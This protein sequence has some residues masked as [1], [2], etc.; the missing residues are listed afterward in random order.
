M[1]TPL[2]AGV[3]KGA[4]QL[5]HQPNSY[6]EH[7]SRRDRPLLGSIEGATTREVFEAYL[8]DVLA[9]SLGPPGQAVVIMWT[10]FRRTRAGG[11]SSLS[12]EL[13]ASLPPYSPNF[14]LMSKPSPRSRGSHAK[15]R[16]AYPRVLLIQVIGQA[17]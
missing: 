16:G 11:S 15:G 6:G 17:L 10:T 12:A 5:G 13:H 14:N 8:E 2:A 4:A 7:H 1:V 9:P 3:P